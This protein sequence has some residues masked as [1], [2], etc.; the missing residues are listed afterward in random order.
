MIVLYNNGI[1]KSIGVSNC[2]ERHLYELSKTSVMPMVNQICVSPLDTK[3]SLLKY[4]TDKHI[5][6]VC[7]APL[8][9]MNSPLIVKA[10]II[11]NLCNKYDVPLASLLLAWNMN[12]GIIPIPKSTN[13]SRLL[14][15][16]IADK[17]ILMEADLKAIDSLNKDI[18]YLPE[19]LFCPGL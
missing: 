19:S 5:Q 7:Y 6:V 8:M 15:N 11:K 12:K 14:S 17:Y 13:K 9:M 18:Q 1:V 10:S 2:R 4:C 3:E 16:F